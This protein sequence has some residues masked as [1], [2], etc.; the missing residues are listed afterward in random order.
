MPEPLTDLQAV[1]EI[2]ATYYQK[3]VEIIVP[4]VLENEKDGWFQQAYHGL[5]K[6]IV[7]DGR[8]KKGR[9]LNYERGSSSFRSFVSRFSDRL[10]DQLLS[11]NLAKSRLSPVSKSEYDAAR[12][13]LFMEVLSLLYARPAAVSIARSLFTIA[14]KYQLSKYVVYVCGWLRKHASESGNMHEFETLCEKHAHWMSLYS[15]EEKAK[16]YMEKINVHFIKSVAQR[17]ELAETAFE[18]AREIE[19]QISKHDSYVLQYHKRKLEALGYHIGCR[20]AEAINTWDDLET[21][22]KANPDFVSDTRLAEIAINKM[23]CYMQLVKHKAA[24]KYAD[25]CEKYFWPGSSNWYIFMEYYFQLAMHAGEYE[26]S[27][28]IMAAVATG[29]HQENMRNT[30]REKWKIFSA[31]NS[32]ASVLQIKGDKFNIKEFLK[33]FPVF[34]QD[35]KGYNV[36]ILI[37]QW[38]ILLRMGTHGKLY[39]IA[40]TLKKYQL[41]YLKGDAD[42][43]VNLFIRM[44]LL[45]DRFQ[46]DY[47]AV[48]EETQETLNEIKLLP[49]IYN[50]GF[51]GLE[52]I[53]FDSLWGMVLRDMK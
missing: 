3:K 48:Y 5:F 26:K 51:D 33:N 21:Y 2:V 30:S 1:A 52:L 42:Y 8:E 46:Y 41:R 44:M 35:K 49:L 4:G 13:Q 9:Y 39:D 38:C 24:W 12:M 7:P 36:S 15:A 22:L 16:E 40:E 11:L 18:Y 19:K 29:R 32:Y 34:S 50:G 45:A 6:G 43:R 14:Q 25:T 10:Y 23:D 17:P 37:I 47:N 27:A 53:P 20:F 28:A 31:Y